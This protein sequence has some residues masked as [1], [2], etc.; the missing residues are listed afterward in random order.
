MSD[1][2]KEQLDAES[3]WRNH[4]LTGEPL[5]GEEVAAVVAAGITDCRSWENRGG[6]LFWN[7][8]LWPSSD[9]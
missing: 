9:P 7:A 1:Q 8:D 3:L 4:V 6:G 2:E 5:T